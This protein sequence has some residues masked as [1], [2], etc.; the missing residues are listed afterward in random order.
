[1]VV[2][3]CWYQMCILRLDTLSHK[4]TLEDY[5]QQCIGVLCFQ[6]SISSSLLSSRLKMILSSPPTMIDVYM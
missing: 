4:K 2:W 5:L 1:M 6:G 3:M